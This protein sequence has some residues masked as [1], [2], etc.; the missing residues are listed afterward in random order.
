MSALSGGYLDGGAGTK[1]RHGCHCGSGVVLLAPHTMRRIVRKLLGTGIW[2]PSHAME[3]QGL[4]RSGGCGI[5]VSILRPAIHEQEIV[6]APSRRKR[7]QLALVECQ[8][9]LVTGAHNYH[10]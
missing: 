7:R 4:Y 10:L 9:E 3:R 5:G 8:P 1:R 2:I 6:T